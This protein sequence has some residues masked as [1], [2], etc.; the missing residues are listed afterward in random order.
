M[1]NNSG[2]T[3]MAEVDPEATTT[4]DGRMR[5]WGKGDFPLTPGRPTG[6]PRAPT[7]IPHVDEPFVYQTPP[8]P[9]TARPTSPP[10]APTAARRLAAEVIRTAHNTLVEEGLAL[11]YG[12]SE[13]DLLGAYRTVFCHYTDFHWAHQGENTSQR[14]QRWVRVYKEVYD[15]S[16]DAYLEAM[17]MEEEARKDHWIR[18]AGGQ[19]DAERAFGARIGDM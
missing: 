11:P 2:Y 1:D 8:R 7:P 14:M 5:L 16:M 18:A 9:T 6:F 13:E 3:L 10:R 12:V 19:T 4:P 17:G 15:P